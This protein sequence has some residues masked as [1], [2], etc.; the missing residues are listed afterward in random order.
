M[1]MD[2]IQTETCAIY[3]QYIQVVHIRPFFQ[4]CIATTAPHTLTHT[5]SYGLFFLSRFVNINE[6]LYTKTSN[7]GGG[8]SGWRRREAVEKKSEKS[9][10][11]KSE[12]KIL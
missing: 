6:K 2:G 1:N 5:C 12:K 9:E 7:S 3:A 4:I 8:R 10:S 11:R